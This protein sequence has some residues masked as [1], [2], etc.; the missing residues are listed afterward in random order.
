MEFKYLKK[1]YDEVKLNNYLERKSDDIAQFAAQYAVD[2]NYNGKKLIIDFINNNDFIKKEFEDTLSDIFKENHIYF[3]SQ[4]FL[5]D[6][7]KDIFNPLSEYDLNLLNKYYLKDCEE[8]RLFIND[9][10]VDFITK[11]IYNKV[12][13][14]YVEYCYDL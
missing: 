12:A 5:S 1:L 10:N 2:N 13:S 7:L 6:A 14:V 8:A 9:L 4:L 11:G 3:E